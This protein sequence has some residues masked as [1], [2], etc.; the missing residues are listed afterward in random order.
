MVLL[1]SF[2]TSAACIGQLAQTFLGRRMCMIYNVCNYR[3]P[4]GK[5]LFRPHRLAGT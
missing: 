3:F 2:S 4:A 5:L 1:K